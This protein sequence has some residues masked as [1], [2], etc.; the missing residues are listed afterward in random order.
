MSKDISKKMVA[1]FIGTAVLVF[2]GCG[3]ASLTNGSLVATSLAFGLSVV[4]M[5]YAIGG[6]SGCHINPAISLG[7][8][9]CKKMDSKEF[10]AYVSSQILGAIFGAILLGLMLG[11]FNSLG[12]NGFGGDGQLAL[13]ES[14]A[15]AAEAFLTFIFVFVVLSVTSDEKNSTISGMVIGLTL[16]LVHLLGIPFTGT[17]VNPAR[18]LGPALIQGG[19]A[20]SQVWVFIIGPLM[21]A[22]LAACVYSYLFTD[23]KV[24]STKKKITKKD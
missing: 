23:G 16:T 24:F 2:V 9:V 13:N 18:S 14:L 22:S 20:L 4:A 8:L 10:V 21:G 7:L 1:E 19:V 6:I 17:S 3:V 5:A 15:F 12:C 11:T